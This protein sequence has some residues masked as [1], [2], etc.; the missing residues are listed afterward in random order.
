MVPRQWVS[1]IGGKTCGCIVV[2]KWLRCGD[3]GVCG[4][5]NSGMVCCRKRVSPVMYKW[6]AG[7]MLA[8]GMGWHRKCVTG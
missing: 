5:H 1:G 3:W 6:H 7:D 4:A 8:G 2:Y